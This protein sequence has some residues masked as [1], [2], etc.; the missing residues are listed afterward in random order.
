MRKHIVKIVVSW[1]VI[2]THAPSFFVIV[3]ARQAY[4]P[5]EMRLNLALTLIPVTATY[6]MA[7]VRDAVEKQGAEAGQG[8]VDFNYYSIAIVTTL[9]FCASLLYFVF[10]FPDVGGPRVEDLQRW[11]I[12]LEIAFGAA[13][14]LIAQDLYGKI[15][16][17][18]VRAAAASSSPLQDR[19]SKT[20]GP[21]RA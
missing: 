11:L 12:V 7:I 20:S 15:E 19:N 3:A 2:L 6:F 18:E 9:L 14:G 13:F 4:F 17:V 8:K 21:R 5:P 10:F 16:K 1:S